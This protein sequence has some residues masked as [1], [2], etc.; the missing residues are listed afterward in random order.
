[1]NEKP[2]VMRDALIHERQEG[3]GVILAALNR[4]EGSN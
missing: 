4:N 1:L 3:N 2:D